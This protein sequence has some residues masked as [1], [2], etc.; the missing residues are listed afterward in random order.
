MCARC[1]KLGT[2]LAAVVFVFSCDVVL[3]VLYFMVAIQIQEVHEEKD[4]GVIV[5]DDLKWDRS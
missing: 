3:N 1:I 2:A 4:L 5:S